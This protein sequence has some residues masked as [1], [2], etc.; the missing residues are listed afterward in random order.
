MNITK[1]EKGLTL[2]ELVVSIAL[3][4]VLTLICIPKNRIND[5]RMHGQAMMLTNDIRMIR[6]LIMAEGEAYHITLGNTD[7]VVMNGFKLVK[8]VEFGDDTWMGNNMKN[9]IMFSYQ[10]RPINA[11]S[12]SIQNKVTGKFHDITIVPYTGRVLLKN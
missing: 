2:V 10:G 1:E 6:S 3:L 8:R 5:Y 7:Y 9:K 12:I 11:G 4:S